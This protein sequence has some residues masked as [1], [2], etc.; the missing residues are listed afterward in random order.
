M[1][2]IIQRLLMF[3]VG[4]PLVV[5]T[6]LFLPQMHHLAAN[7]IIIILSSL[8]AW[9]FYNMLHR[10]KP[11]LSIIEVLLLGAVV[12]TGSTLNVSFGLAG[13][14]IS[15]CFLFGATWLLISRVFS[16]EA[17]FQTAI[18]RISMGF[19]IMVYPGLF[20]M[21]IIRMALLPE[22][23][24]II[25]VFL[26]MVIASDSL[27]WLFGMLFGNG[28][29]G[30]IPASPNKSVAGFIGGIAGSIT[31]GILAVKFCPSVFTS[32][33]I[34]PALLGGILLGFLTCIAAILGDLAESVLKRS[35]NIKDSG[36]IIPGRGGVLDTIDS[37]AL[38]A[39]VYYA[40][41]WLLFI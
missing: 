24:I 21:W 1:K 20:M 26:L 14:W 41:Y 34:K 4:L 16:K 19:S 33:R 25:L 8:G 39:P 17:G 27:A 23:R 11:P 32:I 15:V 3:V 2:K 9:E 40:L 37:I 10:G 31:V 22:S 28:N 38:A 29:R 35:S 7:I 18:E 30:F 6:I 36:N 13:Q 12:T 5:V